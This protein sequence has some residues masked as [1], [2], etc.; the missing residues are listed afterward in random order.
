MREQE[1]GRGKKEC[2]RA[3]RGPRCNHVESP[4]VEPGRIVTR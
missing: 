1:E 2:R 4:I 3:E